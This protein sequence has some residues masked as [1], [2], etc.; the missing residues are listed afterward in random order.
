PGPCH[1]GLLNDDFAVGTG[2]DSA[3]DRRVF[4]FG[5]LA[6]YEEVDVPRPTAGER[7]LHARPQPDLPKIDILIEF[8][9]KENQ[10]SPQRN[11]VGHFFRPAYGSEKD[12]VVAADP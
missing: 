1:H 7:A 5:I 10:R 11:V 9:P 3:A 6:D 2:K 12:G 8:T 4:A